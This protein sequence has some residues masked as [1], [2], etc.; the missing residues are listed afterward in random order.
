MW[1]KM[2][3]DIANL[4]IE[5]PNSRLLETLEIDS[6][7]LEYQ[8]QRFKALEGD[9]QTYSFYESEPAPVAGRDYYVC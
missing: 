4:T 3:Q 6:R 2:V 1:G 9:F 8:L 7:E 5:K